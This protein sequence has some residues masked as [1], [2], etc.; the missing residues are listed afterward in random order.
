M[1]SGCS[2]QH[3]SLGAVLKGAVIGAAFLLTT[4]VFA[5]STVSVFHQLHP[6]VS[7]IEIQQALDALPE[8]GGVVVL[9]QGTITVTRPIVLKRS[10]QTLRGAGV[11][12]VLRLADFNHPNVSQINSVFGS[13][14]APAAGFGQPTAGTGARQIQF[15]LDFEY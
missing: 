14:L 2:N 1:K 13:N 10:H 12:T 7:D 5:G 6:G 15:S 3:A 9:P 8:A 4:N 11:A